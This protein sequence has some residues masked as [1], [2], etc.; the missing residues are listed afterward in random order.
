MEKQIPPTW[1]KKLVSTLT[2]GKVV[3]SCA[4]VL[5]LS[6]AGCGD[7][8]PTSPLESPSDN[9]GVSS[10]PD[11]IG[12]FGADTQWTVSQTIRKSGGT[13]QLDGQ[14]LLCTFEAGALPV[15][16]ALITAQMKLNGP[17]GAA[18][19]LDIDFQPSMNFKK[20]VLLKLDGTYLAGTSSKYVLW[21]FDPAQRTWVRQDERTI[22]STGLTT[23]Q[24][25]HYSAYALTR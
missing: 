1:V 13:M 16:S 18:T 3:A 8:M 15:N 2:G 4:L 6:F 7:N 25:K 22:S 20:D 21:F 9:I 5:A 10:L 24:L 11:L 19:R 23:F 14:R 17:Q 12:K